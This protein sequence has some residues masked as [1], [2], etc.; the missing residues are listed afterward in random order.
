M[1]QLSLVNS[2]PYQVTIY[3]ATSMVTSRQN[4]YRYAFCLLRAWHYNWRF[5]VDQVRRNFNAGE[6]TRINVANRLLLGFMQEAQAYAESTMLGLFWQNIR[7]CHSFL[8][9]ND[10]QLRLPH[11]RSAVLIFVPVSLLLS[12]SS[13]PDAEALGRLFHQIDPDTVSWDPL[14]SMADGMLI[15]LGVP[16]N[17]PVVFKWW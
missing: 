16:R 13:I 14:L 15:H 9:A 11:V 8:D 4:Q 10:I 3:L 6:S 7:K 2:A 5:D 1:T 17:I 12:S